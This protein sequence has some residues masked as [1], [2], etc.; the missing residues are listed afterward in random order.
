MMTVMVDNA[1]VTEADLLASNGVV[2]VVNSIL[3]PPDL[4]MKESNF[5]RK[6]IYLYSVNI[7]G[8]KID[9]NLSNQIVFDVYSS[10]RVIKRFKN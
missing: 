10:G 8:E 4:D 7:L 9:R 6:D 1:L 5:I 2:H 3:L